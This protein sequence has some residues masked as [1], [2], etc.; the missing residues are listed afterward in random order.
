MA[1]RRRQRRHF[2]ISSHRLR[3]CCCCC[4]WMMMV[5]VM[6]FRPGARTRLRERDIGYCGRIGTDEE[7]GHDAR[8]SGGAAVERPSRSGAAAP[9]G[10]PLS[11]PIRSLFRPPDP[12]FIFIPFRGRCP[13]MLRSQLSPPLHCPQFRRPMP[14]LQ[15]EITL[16][17]AAVI[18]GGLHDLTQSS[19]ACRQSCDSSV[20]SS[21]KD[22]ATS[23]DITAG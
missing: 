16:A 7:D 22:R 23:E 12:S 6:Q 14:Q 2:W 10:V 4:T 19:K 9:V 8:A 1:A 20:F 15:L 18:R 17:A 5:L 13:F 3:G 11:T 21:P